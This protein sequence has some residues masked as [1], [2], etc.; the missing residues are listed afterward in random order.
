LDKDREFLTRGGV[1]TND[2]I[3]AYIG[4]KMEEL[5]RFRMTTHPAEFDMHYSL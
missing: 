1:F 4:L 3:D 2:A 5:T